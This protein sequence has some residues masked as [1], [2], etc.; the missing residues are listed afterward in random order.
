VS[1]GVEDAATLEP[2]RADPVGLQEIADRLGVSRRT[3]QQWRLRGLLPEPRWSVGGVPIW[4]WGDIERWAR[5]TGRIKPP[6]DGLGSAATA[7]G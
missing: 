7:E 4:N 2:V 1:A 3:P 6:V 5:E